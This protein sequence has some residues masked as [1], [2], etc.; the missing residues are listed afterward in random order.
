[1]GIGFSGVITVLAVPAKSEL[2]P[3]GSWALIAREINVKTMVKISSLV[4]IMFKLLIGQAW[5]K[6]RIS[7]TRA[8]FRLRSRNPMRNSGFRDRVTSSVHI[9]NVFFFV[10]GV[11]FKIKC[12]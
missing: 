5:L 11:G 8:I 6:R 10:R 9:K 4:L 1:M 2:L 12:C 7:S 3:E